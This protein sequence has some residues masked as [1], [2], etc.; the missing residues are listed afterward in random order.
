MALDSM[1]EIF[2]KAA[3][4]QIP[5]WKVVL[6]TDVEQRQV[7]EEQSMEKMGLT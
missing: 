1:Q 2:E 5:F 4:E 7:T 6:E 3:A